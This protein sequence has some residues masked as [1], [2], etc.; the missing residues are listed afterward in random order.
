MTDL[1]CVVFRNTQNGVLGF[2]SLDGDNPAIFTSAEAA[3]QAANRT[4]VCQT[5][6]FQLVSLAG[7]K[8]MKEHNENDPE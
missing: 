8:T 3:W 6:P 1:F 5:F 4:I 7:L 2:I